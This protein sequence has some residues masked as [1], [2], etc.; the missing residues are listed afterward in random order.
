[1][2]SGRK[3]IKLI[4]RLVCVLPLAALFALFAT[5]AAAQR[6]ISGEAFKE[7]GQFRKRE[8][9]TAKDIKK[10]AIQLD[11]TRHSLARL[12]R[13]EGN[14]LKKRYKSFSGE[15]TKLEKAQKRAIVSID[16]LKATGVEYFSAWE[17]ANASISDTELREAAAIRRSQS[18]TRYIALAETLGEIGLQVESFMSS[19]RDLRAFLGAD[20]ST[21]NVRLASERIKDSQAEAETLKSR[22]AEFQR[23][24]GR[25]LSEMPK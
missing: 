8:E 19:L 17:K 7:S 21:A 25:V 18:L 20:L 1:M 12:G 9:R 23:I 14:E 24:F 10:F 11:K 22:I 13:A 15:V 6:D 3:T 2:L 4:Y 5:V 16:R